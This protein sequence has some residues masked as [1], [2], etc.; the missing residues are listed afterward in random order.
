[1]DR[2]VLRGDETVDLGGTRPRRINLEK[3]DASGEPD[4]RQQEANAPPHSTR[5]DRHRVIVGDRSHVL[6]EE[7]P[8]RATIKGFALACQNAR[9]RSRSRRF[10]D[11]RDRQHF[12]V[13]LIRRHGLALVWYFAGLDPTGCVRFALWLELVPMS[14]V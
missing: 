6:G 14:S 1:M 2:T 13:L 10:A 3:L 12:G 8:R 11:A 5:P 9:S 7:S 4:Q